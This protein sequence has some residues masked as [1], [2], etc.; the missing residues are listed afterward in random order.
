VYFI[1]KSDRFVELNN[2]IVIFKSPNPTIMSNLRVS[3]HKIFMFLFIFMAICYSCVDE[4]LFD[5]VTITVNALENNAPTAF[6]SANILMGDAPLQVNFTG[7]NSSDD[8]GI[9]SYHWDF[10]GNPSSSSDATHTFSDPGV[11]DITLTVTDD[12]GLTDTATLAITVAEGSGGST[13]GGNKACSTNGG[14][15]N[16]SGLKTWCW[17]DITLP[18]YSGTKGVSFSNG[19]LVIDSECNVNALSIDNGQLHFFVDPINPPVD[20]SWCSRDYNMRAEVRTRPWDVRNPLGTEEWFGWSYTFGDDYIIDQNNQWKCFQVYP[21]P[22]GL[23]TNIALEIIHGDQ[24]NGH[25]AGEL[26]ITR[27][28]GSNVTY[29]PSGITPRAGDTLDIVVQVIWG[30]SSNGLYKVWINGGLLLNQ[31]AATT[32]PNTPWGGNAKWGIYKR[33]WENVEQV[34]KSLNQGITHV[35]TSMGNLRM[36]T[37]FPGDVNYGKNSYSEV[38]PR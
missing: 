4:D 8:Y 5:T 26:Y 14:E 9:V 35:N 28:S 11:H 24:F 34:Q 25:Q 6:A 32:H 2:K 22:E 16:E 3:C 7:S 1:E 31:Q 19:E 27:H 17:S 23:S 29:F 13:R 37:R 38:V 21:G 33:A 30:D 36:I 10:P 12:A 18:T 20:K 15:A